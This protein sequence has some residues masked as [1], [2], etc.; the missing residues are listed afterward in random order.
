ML[1]ACKPVRGSRSSHPSHVRVKLLP[2]FVFIA[3]PDCRTVGLATVVRAFPDAQ[4][5]GKKR[6]GQAR[7][8]TAVTRRDPWASEAGKAPNA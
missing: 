6:R 5:E 1:V 4:R 7:A 2:Y 8:G 3:F